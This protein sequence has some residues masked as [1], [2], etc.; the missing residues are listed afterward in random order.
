MLLC[1]IVHKIVF[2]KVIFYFPYLSAHKIEDSAFNGSVL[3][4][5]SEAS[6]I[7]ISVLLMVGNY[8]I[9]LWDDVLWN[10]AYNNAR[11]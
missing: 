6:M 1:Y 11:H 3:L 2:W 5:A 8:K 10:D 4:P 9:L 7:A